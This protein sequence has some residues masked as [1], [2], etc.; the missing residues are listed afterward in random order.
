MHMGVPKWRYRPLAGYEP[1]CGPIPP[2]GL[3]VWLHGCYG[4]DTS[5]S[6]DMHMM[7]HRPALLSLLMHMSRGGLLLGR[8]LLWSRL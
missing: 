8:Y 4:A 3:D 5:D 2:D 7:S 1:V 6:S